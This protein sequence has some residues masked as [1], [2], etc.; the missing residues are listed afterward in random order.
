[1]ANTAQFNDYLTC[2]KACWDAADYLETSF[3]PGLDTAWGEMYWK[4][5]GS[6]GGKNSREL[7]DDE[8]AGVDDKARAAIT[9]LRSDATTV[10]EEYTTKVNAVLRQEYEGLLTNWAYMNDAA[11][12]YDEDVRLGPQTAGM[13]DRPVVP[14]KPTLEQISTPQAPNFIS[15]FFA[16][17][18]RIT[19][20]GSGA[21]VGAGNY[22]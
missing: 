9:A 10:A 2:A 14:A 6:S 11:K 21:P 5:T 12:Q 18:T 17:P 3:L 19:V 16:P 15:E 7:A 4:V 20:G 13:G 8:K 1:M 22:R